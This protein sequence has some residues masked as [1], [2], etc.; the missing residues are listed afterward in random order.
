[1]TGEGFYW[2]EAGGGRKLG[3]LKMNGKV[4]RPNGTDKSLPVRTVRARRTVAAT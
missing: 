1:M 2:R 3:W 4:R